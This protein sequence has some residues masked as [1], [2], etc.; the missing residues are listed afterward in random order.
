MCRRATRALR[1]GAPWAGWLAL[2]LLAAGCGP[3]FGNVS[4]TVT[5]QG[6]PLAGGTITFFDAANRSTSGEIKSDGTYVVSK[7]ACGRARIAVATPMDIPFKG[8]NEGVKMDMGA[9]KPSPIPDRY[10]D[11]DKSGLT[12][13]VTAPEQKHDVS[14]D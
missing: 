14:L 3:R 12:C 2:L 8:M 6:K 11:A 9:P 10:A 5:Y 13:E 1:R 4:G 7:V